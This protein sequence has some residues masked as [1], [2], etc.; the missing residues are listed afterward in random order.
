MASPDTTTLIIS[1]DHENLLSSLNP[2]CTVFDDVLIDGC[3]LLFEN[4][5]TID[6]IIFW[7][8]CYFQRDVISISTYAGNN[9]SSFEARWHILFHLL[10]QFISKCNSEIIIRID[11][12][13]RKLLQKDCVHVLF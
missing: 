6:L 3:F 4:K 2:S 9:G 1:L 11:P 7:Y 13:L 5:F 10:L 8:M 12:H